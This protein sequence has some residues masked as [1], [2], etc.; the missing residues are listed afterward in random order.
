MRTVCNEVQT[1]RDRAP[2]RPSSHPAQRPNSAQSPPTCLPAT[3][4]EVASPHL[5]P[6]EAP[7]Q[8]GPSWPPAARHMGP[9]EDQARKPARVPTHPAPSLKAPLW[10]ASGARERKSLQERRLQAGDLFLTKNGEFSSSC[11]QQNCSVWEGWGSSADSPELRGRPGRG[12]ELSQGP[13]TPH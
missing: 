11:P 2:G 13:P 9:G 1:L 6:G 12:S 7:R 3:Q 5:P 8:P 10:E 4:A